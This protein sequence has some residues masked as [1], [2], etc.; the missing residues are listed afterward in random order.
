VYTKELHLTFLKK[1]SRIIITLLFIAYQLVGYGTPLTSFTDEVDVFLKKYVN[2]GLV[3]YSKIKE[4]KLEIEKLYRDAGTMDLGKAT[5]SEKKAFYINAYN[6]VVIHTVANHYPIASPMDVGG[7]FD[8]IK[9]LISGENLTLNE[10]ENKKLRQ[11]YADGRL[12]FALV[13]AAKSCPSLMGEAYKSGKIEEQLNARTRITL[14]DPNWIK[15]FPKQKKVEISKI[16]EWYKDDFTSERGSALDW[17]NQFRKEKIPA[18]Y[19]VSFYEYDWTLNK[20]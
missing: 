8:K 19:D 12:H 5:A 3:N 16:F 13:C 4:N 15:V 17:I 14:N 2:N 7:F 1:M 20:Y 11:V 9:H 6:I 10:L 18:T